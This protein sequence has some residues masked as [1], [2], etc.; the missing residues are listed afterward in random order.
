MRRGNELF[1]VFRA[2]FCT[3]CSH[4]KKKNDLCMW[5]GLVLV[6]WIMQDM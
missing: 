6:G 3:P 1:L 5:T 2:G 4:A